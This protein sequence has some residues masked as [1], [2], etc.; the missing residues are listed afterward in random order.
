MRFAEVLGFPAERIIKDKAIYHAN[1]ST[2]LNVIR[3]IKGEDS[4][5]VMI[6]GH[7]P[8]LTDF[9][10]DLLDE[11]IANIPTAGV[12]SCHLTID[13]WASAEPGCGEIEFFDYPKLAR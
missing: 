3:Q 6:F 4:D 10:N 5:L 8:G 9:T 7:N 1:A 11:N 13:L 2:L 12:V